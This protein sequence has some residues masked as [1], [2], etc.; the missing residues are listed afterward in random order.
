L[1]AL[2]GILV[3]V[4]AAAFIA[5]IVAHD[6]IIKQLEMSRRRVAFYESGIARLKG[7]W[8]GGGASGARFADPF[9]PFSADLD[10]FGRGSLFE[11]LCTARTRAGEDTLAAWLLDGAPP[12]T[13]RARQEAVRELAPRLDLREQL[14]LLG[15]DVRSSTNPAELAVWGAEPPHPFAPWQRGAAF[16]LGTVSIAAVVLWFAG[17]GPVPM[18]A[19]AAAGQLFAYP[20]RKRVKQIVDGV[21]KPARDLELLSLL[22]ARIESEPFQSPLL[23]DMVMGLASES[24]LA[25]RRIARLERLV[26]LLESRRNMIFAPFAFL[27]LWQEQFAFAIEAWRGATGPRVAGWL[28]AIGEFEALSA[29]ANYAWE[30]PENTYPVIQEHGLCVEAVGA[31]HPLLLR[32]PAVANDVRLD[33]E[34]RALV[35][36]GSNMSGKSTLLRT[37]GTNVVLALAGAP[38]RAASFRVS[39]LR[40]GASIRTQDSLQS[41]VSR[42]YAEI[43][44]LRQIMELTDGD[45]PVLF[46][47][48]EILHGTNSHDRL[49][50]AEAVVRG[51]LARGAIGL[52]TTHDLA[53]ARIAEEPELH[54]AN[55]HFQDEVR[56]GKMAF[57][58]RL[59][60]GVVTRSNALDLMRSVGLPV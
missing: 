14:A 4:P 21:G 43:K 49:I 10:L 34:T 52:V 29:L 41:G 25:S 13:I 18:L 39:P 60:P 5:A 26:D 42:F 36:S 27:A 56:D 40:L 30:R 19:A 50:G 6:R 28:S 1:N 37:I 51:L 22:L 48:D 8:E 11:L 44:R 53:L 46:L 3:L 9:H 16:V 59:K 12:D 54:V 20:F 23:R 31:A 38:V 35:V 45:T 24:E 55:V 32:G 57:D 15:T 47:L 33:S 7:E 58:Y 2:P 17:F